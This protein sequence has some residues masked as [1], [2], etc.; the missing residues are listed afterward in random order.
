MS[1]AN[2]AYNPAYTW[3]NPKVR[4]LELQMRQP[5]FSRHPLEMGVAGRGASALLRISGDTSYLEP[6]T[7][8]FPNDARPI[9]MDHI[10]KAIAAFERTLISGRSPFDRYVFDDDRSAMTESARRGMALFYS[11][12]IG[13]SQCHFGINFSGPLLYEGHEHA[14]AAFAN[15]GL[16]DLD[17]RGSY[18]AADQ[19]LIEVTHRPADMGKFRVPTLRNVG[20]TPPYMHDGSVATLQDVIDHYSGAGH[21]SVRR[22]LRIRGFAITAAERQDLIDFLYSLT[23]RDFIENPRFRPP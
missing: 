4:S 16:Y 8:A 3:S 13:C 9:S 15:T 1:L 5:L 10:I 6:F 2:V 19:G 21:R 22:D 23:D 18:P 12:R 20:V 17:G 11:A 14:V 7:A